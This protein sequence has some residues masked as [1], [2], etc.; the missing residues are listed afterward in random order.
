MGTSYRYRSSSKEW[1]HL[2]QGVRVRLRDGGTQLQ[3]RLRED[4]L[5]DSH[6]GHHQLIQGWHPLCPEHRVWCVR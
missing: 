1:G 6:I 2:D 3:H 4:V 5:I